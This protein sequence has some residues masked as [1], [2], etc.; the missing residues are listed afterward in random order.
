MG[1]A[2]IPVSESVY[3]VRPIQHG[4]MRM[5]TASVCLQL[6]SVVEHRRLFLYADADPAAS[7]SVIAS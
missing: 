6:E 5:I 2:T 7:V 3:E 1:H 4:P